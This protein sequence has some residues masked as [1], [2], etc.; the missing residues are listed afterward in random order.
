[1]RFVKPAIAALGLA[2]SGCVVAPP[3]GP[4]IAM[5]A[6]PARPPQNCRE[7]QQTITVGGKPQ[8]A[9]G[10]SCQQ[11]DGTWKVVGQDGAASQPPPPPPVA[12]YPAYPPPP[13]VMAYPAYYPGYYYPPFYGR[14]HLGFGGRF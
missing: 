10:T 14:V 7:F 1:M 12:T 11:P 3:P 9:Y 8:K 6:P 4:P 2:C 13:P 5:A